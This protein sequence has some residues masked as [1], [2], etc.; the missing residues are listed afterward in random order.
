MSYFLLKLFASFCKGIAIS[1][2]SLPMAA[3]ASE[4]SAVG[5]RPFTTEADLERVQVS[6]FGLRSQILELAVSIAKAKAGNSL[7]EAK[8]VEAN[9]ALEEAKA[10]IEDAKAEPGSI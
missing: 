3:S 2:S 10:S 4:G 8:L 7:A 5:N 6:F 1:T 9:V